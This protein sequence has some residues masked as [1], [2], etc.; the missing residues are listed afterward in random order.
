MSSSGPTIFRGDEGRISHVFL[1]SSRFK[2]LPVFFFFCYPVIPFSHFPVIKFSCDF[3]I[4]FPV[5]SISVF[6]FS[7]HAVFL[8]SHYSIPFSCYPNKSLSS[9][10]IIP[11]FRFTTDL[12]PCILCLRK[13]VVGSLLR[14]SLRKWPCCISPRV[15]KVRS[16]VVRPWVRR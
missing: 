8:L 12:L 3:N 5:I 14:K 6:L 16:V 10:P 7:H 11:L 1:F 4:R 13:P 15:D 2:S 9:Y